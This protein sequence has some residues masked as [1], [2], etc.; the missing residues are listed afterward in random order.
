MTNVIWAPRSTYSSGRM[1]AMI[2]IPTTEKEPANIT[3]DA[4]TKFACERSSSKKRVRRA[5]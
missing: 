5:G 2:P 1:A 4:V 3:T